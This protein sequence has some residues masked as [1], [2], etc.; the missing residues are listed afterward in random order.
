MAVKIISADQELDLEL[1]ITDNF[2][3]QATVDGVP[4]W[5]SG[6]DAVIALTVSDDGFTAV[7]SAV[8]PVGTAQ[9][10]VRADADVGEGLR[11][12]IATLDLEVVGGEARLVALNA[13]EP[14]VKPEPT[15]EPVPENPDPGEP[16]PI[17]DQDTE[18]TDPNAP[19]P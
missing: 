7:A 18:P 12:I 13:G 17:P 2:G 10:S 4:A 16:A 5:T 19:T 15:P 8:G 6:D 1:A 9:V 14:R 3:N 11:E